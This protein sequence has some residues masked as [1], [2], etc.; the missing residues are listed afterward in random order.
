[1]RFYIATA[2]LGAELH[3]E[4][5]VGFGVSVRYTP[6]AGGML[7]LVDPTGEVE[8]LVVATG[9]DV[10]DLLRARDQLAYLSATGHRPPT[11]EGTHRRT[12]AAAALDRAAILLEEASCCARIGRSDL[13]DDLCHRATSAMH[14]G[15]RLLV[16]GPVEDV[17]ED[18]LPH[19]IVR[20]GGERG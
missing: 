18:E 4:L 13:L 11:R 20:I 8:H 19:N 1:M 3:T 5:R 12:V 9:D 17:D 10:A 14:T 6:D 16:R 2:L 15:L 7:E